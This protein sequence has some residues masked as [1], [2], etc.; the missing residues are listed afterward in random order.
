MRDRKLERK[1]ARERIEILLGLAKLAL[2]AEPVLS[3][4]YVAL[5]RRLGSRYN[6]AFSKRWLCKKCNT[7]LLPGASCTVRIRKGVRIL[8]CSGCGAVK[9]LPTAKKDL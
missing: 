2:K 1:I 3:K 8:I 9:R 5:A 7:V 4:R 6:V